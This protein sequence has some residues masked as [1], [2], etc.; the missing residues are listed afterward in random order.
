MRHDLELFDGIRRWPH[1][2]AA[3][4]RIVVWR[5]IQKEVVRLVAHAVDV[6]AS[7]GVAEAAG[8]GVSI[9]SAKSCRSGNHAWNQRSELGEVSA[10]EWQ[11]DDVLVVDNCAERRISC[12]HQRSGVGH[13]DFERLATHLK[14]NVNSR[15]AVDGNFYALGQVR[16]EPC[17]AHLHLVHPWVH[18]RNL[19][20]A[21]GTRYCGADLTGPGV[22]QLY[23]GSGDD[24]SCRI[25]DDTSDLAGC[26]PKG[27]CRQEEEWRCEQ[28]TTQPSTQRT[29][30]FNIFKSRGQIDE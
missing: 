23:A 27:G 15:S 19:K 14:L 17:E 18:Q 29:L 5:A 16:L 7:G 25:S 12:F 22:R 4:E 10:I 6:E 3:V 20:R 9:G 26:L 1:D 11:I 30:F 24:S 21:V 28:Q 2:E 8:G 13:C